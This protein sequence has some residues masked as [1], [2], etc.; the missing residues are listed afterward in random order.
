LKE[1]HSWGKIGGGFEQ[2]V[3]CEA[4]IAFPLLASYVYH[5]GSWKGRKPKCYNSFL[6]EVE[7]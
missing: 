4:T 1:A 5:R 3:F 6:D 2:M 7:S